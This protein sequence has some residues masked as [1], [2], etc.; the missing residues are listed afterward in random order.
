MC[1]SIWAVTSWAH[2]G[3]DFLAGEFDVDCAHL[4]VVPPDDILPGVSSAAAKDAARALDVAAGPAEARP[5]RVS[6]LCQ[7]VTG[8]A[9]DVVNAA[10]SDVC[11]RCAAG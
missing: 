11:W 3:P 4:V 10:H 9:Y 2:L 7:H 8:E 5:D 1:C 6:H